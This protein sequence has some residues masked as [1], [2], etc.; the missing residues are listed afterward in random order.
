M[1]ITLKNIW[2]LC[3][4]EFKSVLSDYV[5]MGLIV[6]MFSVATYSVSK[7][8]AVEVKNGSVAVINEDQS[9]LSWRIIDALKAPHFQKPV[10][11]N[12]D[13]INELMDRGQYTF[14]LVIPK[15]YEKDLLQRYAPDLQ[16]LIDATAVSQ[17]GLGASFIQQVVVAETAAYFLKENPLA[18]LPMNMVTKVLFNPNADY[19]W[20][21]GPMQIVSNAALLAMLLVGAAIIR[22]KERGTIEHLLVMP[23]RAFEIALAKVISNAMVITVASIVSLYLVIHLWLGVPLVGS[24]PL[25]ILSLIIFLFAVGSLG[26]LLSTFAPTMPQFGLLVIPVY[27]I[28]RL[29]SGGESPREGMPDWVQFMTSF[30]PQTQFVQTTQNLLTRQAGLETI[31]P[32]LIYMSIMAIVFFA[33][34]LSRFKKM[35]ANQG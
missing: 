1:W 23:V 34:A 12:H 25:F 7:G 10:L 4:K 20:F 28:M 22:E 35:L 9:A 3:L 26:I 13:E 11:I 27:M 5:L 6:V 30:S 8:M 14:V 19:T 32:N 33:L 29:L 2:Y 31:W 15:D 18:D 21:A 24:V 16:L 17:S